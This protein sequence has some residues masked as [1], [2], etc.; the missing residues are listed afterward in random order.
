MYLNMWE[1]SVIIEGRGINAKIRGDVWMFM[2]KITPLLLLAIVLA[3][4]QDNN[5]NMKEDVTSIEVYACCKKDGDLIKEITDKALIDDLV[6]DLKK[7]DTGTTANLDFLPPEYELYFKTD[8]EVV[9]EMGYFTEV[10]DLDLDGRYWDFNN[11]R[12]Y[13]VDHELPIE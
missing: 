13:S 12:M 8:D 7:A 3:G 10:K 11:D 6:K 9:Y 2:R 5:L 1:F 4:C